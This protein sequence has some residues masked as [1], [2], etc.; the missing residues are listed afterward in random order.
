MANIGLRPSFEE[1]APALEVNVFDF[2]GDLYGSVLE[3]RLIM[4]LRGQLKFDSL[5][6][7]KAQL[8]QDAIAARAAL[9]GER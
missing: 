3:V 5:D 6:D 1:K 9:K 4:H 2:S 8:Q 7:L